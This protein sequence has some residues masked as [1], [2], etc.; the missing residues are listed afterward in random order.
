[1][2]KGWIP[3]SLSRV[4]SPLFSFA[5]IDVDL[6]EPIFD[7]LCFVYE[8]MSTG[9]SILLDDYG[10]P[11][12]YGAKQATDEFFK[13]KKEEIIPLPTGQANDILISRFLTQ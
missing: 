10:F 7:S 11:M 4:T 12:L 6:Y 3:E 1:M 5:H 9:E 13:N 8:K 2:I